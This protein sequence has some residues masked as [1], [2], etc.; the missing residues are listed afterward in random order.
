MNTVE[1]NIKKQLSLVKELANTTSHPELK[2][3]LLE[4][5]A[6]LTSL[7]SE[8]DD[9][10]KKAIANP[11]DASLQKAVREVIS[12]AKEEE[13]KISQLTKEVADVRSRER[14]NTVKPIDSRVPK[15]IADALSEVNAFNSSLPKETP[16]GKLVAASKVSYKITNK[17]HL[18]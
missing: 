12:R 9:L 2:K 17:S 14:R 15:H 6:R 11:S 10:C 16:Q 7:L 1:E 13:V 18:I 8:I 3:A 4:S 5:D